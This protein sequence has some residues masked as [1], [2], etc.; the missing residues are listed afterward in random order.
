MTRDSLDDLLPES[1]TEVHADDLFDDVSSLLRD[2]PE[3]RATKAELRAHLE[4]ADVAFQ[5]LHEW[6][7]ACNPLPDPWRRFYVPR[8]NEPSPGSV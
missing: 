2:T 6:L 8:T 4:R 1:D 3:S 7:M 5:A